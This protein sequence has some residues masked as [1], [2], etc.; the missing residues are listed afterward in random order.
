MGA[1]QIFE[2][3]NDWGD[4]EKIWGEGRQ[5]NDHQGLLGGFRLL[6]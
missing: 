1:D 2:G 4:I 6:G 3:A 5:T